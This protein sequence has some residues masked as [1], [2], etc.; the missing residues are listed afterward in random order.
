MPIAMDTGGAPEE[1]TVVLPHWVVLHRRGSTRCHNSLDAA[2]VAVDKNKTAAPLDMDGG[3][4]CYVSFTL[5]PPQKGI[6]C[7]N[8]HLPEKPPLTPGIP[9]T[10]YSFLRATDNNLVLFDISNPEKKDKKLVLV[11]ISNPDRSCYRQPPADLFVYKAGNPRPSVQCLPPYLEYSTRPFLND[12]LT[13]G[14]LQLEG[15]RFVV[16]DLNVY[17][18]KK[19]MRAEICVFN[20]ET[21]KWKIISKIDLGQFPELWSTHYVLAFDGRFLCWVDYFSGVLLCDFSKNIDSPSLCYVP[22]P[23]G[24]EYPDKVRVDRYFPERFQSVSI[25]QGKIYFVRID[26]DFHDRIHGR[27]RRCPELH[28]RKRQTTQNITIWTLN[29]E[30]D[31]KLHRIINLDSLWVQAGYR[32]LQIHQRLPE[33]PTI[34]ADDPDVL[35]CLLTEEEFHGNGWMIMLDMKNAHLQS[36]E[37]VGMKGHVNKFPNAPLLPTAF[38]KYLERPTGMAL[39]KDKCTGLS[40][41]RNKRKHRRTRDDIGQGQAYSSFGVWPKKHKHTLKVKDLESSDIANLK[42]KLAEPSQ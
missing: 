13:T 8:L 29:S 37:S 17:H 23:G 36:C 40:V 20:S 9:P 27:C 32:D 31:W 34:S 35:C 1:E 41:G 2:R 7:L 25:S 6:S 19:G 16:A 39:D 15:D 33:F 28:D 26:N 10:A 18:K 22:F 14:I 11:D 21:E 42:I 4:S 38:C 3:T 30:L 5:A 24:K 12:Y